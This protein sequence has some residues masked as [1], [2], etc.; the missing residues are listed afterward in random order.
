MLKAI[1]NRL[2]D[3][4]PEL[5]RRIDGAAEFERL[6]TSREAPSAPLSAFLVPSGLQGGAVSASTGFFTQALR[7]SIAVI[8]VFRTHSATGGR[9][10]PG[11]RDTIMAVINALCGWAPSDETGVFQLARAA[12]LTLQR[13]SAF[14]QIDLTIT[15]QLRI[16]P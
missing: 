4:V 1:E 15:D 6:V 13:G 12:L 2:V 16:T 8:L 7:E 11:M 5:A 10:L 14:Y 3:Q 9:D